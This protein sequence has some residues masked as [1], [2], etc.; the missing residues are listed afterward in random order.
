[1]GSLICPTNAEGVTHRSPGLPDAGGLPWVTVPNL[2]PTLKGLNRALDCENRALS[3]SRSL[4]LFR[5]ASLLLTT[6]ARRSEFIKSHMDCLAATDFFTTEVWTKNGLVTFFVLFVIDLA[7]RRVEI[8]GITVNPDA[9]WMKQMAC[10]LTDSEDGFLRGKR[11]ILMDRDGKYCAEFRD[12][13]REAGV[14]PLRLPP[15]SPNLNSYAERFVR[16]IKSSPVPPNIRT[17]TGQL[18]ENAFLAWAGA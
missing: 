5:V 17:K 13:L 11:Y 16:S 1:M 12:T 8:A 14:K 4:T 10:N 6:T 7:S 2:R 3:I 15:R 9:A 18:G